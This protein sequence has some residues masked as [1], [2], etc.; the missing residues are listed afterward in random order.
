[1]HSARAENYY[2][3]F[4]ESNPSSSTTNN[5]KILWLL[6]LLQ[7]YETNT[8][9]MPQIFVCEMSCTRTRIHALMLNIY[10]VYYGAIWHKAIVAIKLQRPSDNIKNDNVVLQ[11]PRLISFV[12][13][14]HAW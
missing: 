6:S 11:R 12:C 5:N 10:I 4:I 14:E 13:F 8:F 2:F 7:I 9:N 1:M 3:V